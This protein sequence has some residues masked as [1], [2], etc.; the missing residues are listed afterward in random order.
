MSLLDH[1]R[2]SAAASAAAVATAAGDEG[3]LSALE[4][5]AEAVCV[6]VRGGGKV[7]LF[8]NGGSAAD[9]QHLAGEFVGRFRRERDAYPA[10]SLVT[11]S[12]VMSA[13]ANDYGYDDV[14]SRQVKALAAEGDVVM[15]FSTSGNS[16][17]VVRAMEAARGAGAK[18]VG[19]TGSDG[20]RLAGAVDIALI[21]PAEETRFIQ[22][23]HGVLIHAL[24]EAVEAELAGE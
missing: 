21:A 18:T 7:L 9:C 22:D 17:A 14:F 5:V 20:G 11:D 24:C 12:S 8:G 13:I 1:I 23:V 4:A 15:G 3:L 19:W 16:E 6:S 10:V 2:K